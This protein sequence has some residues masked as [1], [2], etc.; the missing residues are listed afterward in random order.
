MTGE[1]TGERSG[2][3]WAPTATKRT[4]QSQSGALTP[5]LETGVSSSGADRLGT[6]NSQATAGTG[7]FRVAGG[8]GPAGGGAGGPAPPRSGEFSGSE[9]GDDVGEDVLD[10]IAHGQKNHDDYDRNQDQDQGVLDHALAALA[11]EPTSHN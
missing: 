9:S 1:R 6:S 4:L 3:G 2:S 5:A 10:L 11:A 7:Q 8:L